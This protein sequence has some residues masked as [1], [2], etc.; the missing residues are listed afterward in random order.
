MKF[1]ITAILMVLFWLPAVASAEEQKS[2]EEELKI[3]E[4]RKI[5]MSVHPAECSQ[6]RRRI[7]HFTMMM[8]RAQILENPMWEERMGMQMANLREIQKLR[9][10]KDIPIDTVGIAITHFLKLASRAALTYFTFGAAG[11]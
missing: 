4:M 1:L 8:Q 7:D 6:L 9:C 10:P 11:F 2:L 3:E 5:A